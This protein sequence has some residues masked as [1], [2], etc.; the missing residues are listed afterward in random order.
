MSPQTNDRFT[1]HTATTRRK[2]HPVRR[3]LSFSLEHEHERLRLA[4]HRQHKRDDDDDD[5]AFDDGR[6]MRSPRFFP[7]V[8][9][10]KL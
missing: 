8:Y 7:L 1:F 9:E 5:D 10:V 2:H 3:S 6:Y 4:T